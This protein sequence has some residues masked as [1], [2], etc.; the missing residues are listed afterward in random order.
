MFPGGL[1]WVFFGNYLSVAFLLMWKQN[2]NSIKC[3]NRNSN[4]INKLFKI[5]NKKYQKKTKTQSAKKPLNLIAFF[6]S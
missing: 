6:Q 5:K 3:R 4:N 1:A 2:G